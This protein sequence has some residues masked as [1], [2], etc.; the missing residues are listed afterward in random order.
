MSYDLRMVMD[1][2]AGN[3]RSVTEWRNPTYNLGEMF[4]EALG[5]RIREMRGVTGAEAEPILR[6]AVAAM[7]S[8]PL[9]FKALNPPNGW[10]CYEDALNT[11]RWMLEESM[12][13]PSA[14][15]QT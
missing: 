14:R 15:W 13:C 11:L 1:V 9:R 7:E 4:A 6:A 3:E 12:T 2:G 8:D 10:G 5:R